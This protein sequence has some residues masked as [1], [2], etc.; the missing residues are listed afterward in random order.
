M[1][2]AIWGLDGPV[3]TY[4]EVIQ[5]SFA[6]EDSAA[7]KAVVFA[8]PEQ[9]DTLQTLLRGT[10]RAHAVLIVTPDKAATQKCPGV[11]G[12]R[13]TYRTVAV[14]ESYT[15]GLTKPQP[16]AMAKAV[17]LEQKTSTVIYVRYFQRYMVAEKWKEAH[18]NPQRGVSC[19]HGPA[20]NEGAGLLGVAGGR[21]A[22]D[23]A[24]EDL[25]LCSGPGGGCA[26]APRFKRGKGGIFFDVSRSYTMPPCYTEWHDQTENE[27]SVEYLR[28]MLT[29]PPDFGLVAGIAASWASA[30]SERRG[31]RCKGTGS[32]MECP[33]R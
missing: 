15:N 26:V 28:R 25:R 2:A 16:R 29:L 19:F 33:G 4:E 13:V 8:T 22:T 23:R 11:S 6:K 31:R 3:L 27:S 9:R 30:L 18:R 17:K 5:P 32:L 7:V 24:A 14:H 20:Q 12:G 1:D 10:G 21:S